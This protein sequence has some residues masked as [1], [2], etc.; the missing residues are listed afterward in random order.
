MDT[1]KQQ[2]RELKKAIQKEQ[3][4]GIGALSRKEFG[5]LFQNMN[6]KLGTLESQ[7]TWLKTIRKERE[8][9]NDP[10]GIIDAFSVQVPLRQWIG[11]SN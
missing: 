8:H 7:K 2:S 9:I 1:N 5:H 10:R 11:L 6:H 4:L 3:K